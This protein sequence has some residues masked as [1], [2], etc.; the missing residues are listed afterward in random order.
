MSEYHH[1]NGCSPPPACE[2][3]LPHWCH[4][5]GKS[6]LHDWLTTLHCFSHKHPCMYSFTCFVLCIATDHTHRH[7]NI[8]H[9][10][11]FNWDT[12]QVFRWLPLSINLTT[13]WSQLT[14]SALVSQGKGIYFA[15]W[16]QW[17]LHN[18]IQRIQTQ[19]LHWC[20]NNISPL[21]WIIV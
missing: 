16:G 2:W 19:T 14:L 13:L 18:T 20:S 12:S 6:V 3:L 17:L 21:T 5:C 7:K 8:L 11:W 1:Q 9:T 4:S 15:S 10:F